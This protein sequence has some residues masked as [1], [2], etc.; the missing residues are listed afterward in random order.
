MILY[1]SAEEISRIIYTQLCPEP[2]N[3]D[4]FPKN[5][6]GVIQVMEEDAIKTKSKL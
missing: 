4:I 5:Y 1:K 3:A 2:I 6:L